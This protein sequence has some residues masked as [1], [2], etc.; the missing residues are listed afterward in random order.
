MGY[1]TFW[2]M[3]SNCLPNSL[4]PMVDESDNFPNTFSV[5]TVTINHFSFYYFIMLKMIFHICMCICMYIYAFIITEIKRFILLFKWT[6]L[7]SFALPP[8][9]GLL[10]FSLHF[11]F[12]FFWW[13]EGF[14]FFFETESCYVA[15]AGLKL[16]P[17]HPV[18]VFFLLISKNS[19]H[20]K[21]FILDLS[22]MLQIFVNMYYLSLLC[23]IMQQ[24]IF[25]KCVNTIIWN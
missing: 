21:V 14:L 3:W 9:M 7:V 19:L 11:F 15:Q 22:C 12:F 2:W 5:C 17:L 1:F 23:V 6:P 25:P 16:T 13:G 10:G 24:W 4:F 18:Q 8:A 20:S